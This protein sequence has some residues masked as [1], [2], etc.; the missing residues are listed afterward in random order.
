M[1]TMIMV[2]VV[3][4]VLLVVPRALALPTR[5][6]R[7]HVD[8]LTTTTRRRLREAMT[9]TTREKYLKLWVH[10]PDETTKRVLRAALGQMR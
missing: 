4:V 1:M 2:V 8:N 5:D 3:V 7:R 6:L 10:A 9:P